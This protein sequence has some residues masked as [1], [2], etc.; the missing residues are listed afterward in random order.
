MSRL[1]ARCIKLKHNEVRICML[2]SRPVGV[3]RWDMEGQYQKEEALQG[4]CA[5]VRRCSH[6]VFL[7]MRQL[8]TFSEELQS[9][10]R[11]IR[12]LVDDFLAAH[13]APRPSLAPH[14][15][16]SA[17]RN[18]LPPPSFLPA[19]PLN[20]RQPRLR[21][22]CQS[23]PSARLEQVDGTAYSTGLQ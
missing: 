18:A 23:P 12:G 2:R 21:T 19:A 16:I 10:M 9:T 15:P 6:T 8:M 5:V 11:H 1:I 17:T 4:P 20:Q 14:K 3:L 22:G 7:W 13:F